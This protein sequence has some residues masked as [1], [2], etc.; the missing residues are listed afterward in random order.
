[1]GGAWSAIEQEEKVLRR[2][3]AQ[4]DIIE[5]I[6]MIE[7]IE[8]E[9][10]QSLLK[11]YTEEFEKTFAAESDDEDGISDKDLVYTKLPW[12]SLEREEEKNNCQ[13]YCKVLAKKEDLLMQLQAQH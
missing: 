9:Y 8:S 6:N 13:K 10:G 3:E 2:Q 5:E 12:E 11:R 7:D 1:M 4:N